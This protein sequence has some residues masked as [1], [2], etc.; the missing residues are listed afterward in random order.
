MFI[1]IFG[2][3]VIKMGTDWS[4]ND[5]QNWRWRRG[6]KWKYLRNFMFFIFW[7]LP[8]AFSVEFV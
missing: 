4:G 5:C 6:S 1:F 7:T 2:V 8:L 3:R